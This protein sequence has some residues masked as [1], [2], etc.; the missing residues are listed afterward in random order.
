MMLGSIFGSF[1]PVRL[2]SL[3]G[4]LDKDFDKGL[5]SINIDYVGYIEYVR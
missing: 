2:A 1:K 3:C 5:L 4:G